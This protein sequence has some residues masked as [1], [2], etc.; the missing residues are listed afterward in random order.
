MNKW[1]D[2]NKKKPNKDRQEYIL[3]TRERYVGGK[4]KWKIYTGI[5]EN[6]LELFLDVMTPEYWMSLPS[7]PKGK[8]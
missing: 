2:F 5:W 6:T 3:A 8:T 1:I 7:P 4:L